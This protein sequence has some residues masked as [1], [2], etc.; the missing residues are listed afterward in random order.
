MAVQARALCWLPHTHLAG[1]WP[2]PQP[3]RLIHSF[4]VLLNFHAAGSFQLCCQAGTACRQVP[5]TPAAPWQPCQQGQA[6]PHH[7]LC[8][9]AHCYIQDTN[10]CCFCSLCQG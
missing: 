8:P 9:V 10:C 2:Q 6:A 5:P 1:C 3:R 7:L 4:F